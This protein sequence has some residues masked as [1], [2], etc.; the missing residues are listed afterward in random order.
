M[1]IVIDGPD[2]VGKSTLANAI[3]ENTKGSLIHCTYNKN[4]DMEYYHASVIEAADLLSKFTPVVVDRWA[5]SEAVYGKVFRGGESYNTK[6]L[7]NEWKNLIIWIY[8]RNDN[9][10]KN[11]QVN[12]L[13]RDEMFKDMEKIVKEFDKYINKSNLPWITY[14]YNKVNFNEFVNKITRK[15]TK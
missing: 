2:G 11:H 4:F 6:K 12:L 13:K 8:C 1:I 10:V 9:A 15:A 3:K 7:I 5:P 14:D